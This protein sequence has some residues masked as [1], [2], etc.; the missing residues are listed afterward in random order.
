M[1]AK[2]LDE[3]VKHETPRTGGEEAGEAAGGI[4]GV[5]LGAAIGSPAGPIGTIIGGIAGAV[6][7]WWAGRAVVDATTRFTHE[8]DHYYRERYAGSPRRLD[9]RSY[10]QVRA[11][12]QLGH[13]AA[14]NP[15]YRGCSFDDIEGDLRSGWESQP[16]TPALG[17]DQVK[18]YV[19]EGYTRSAESGVAEASAPGDVAADEAT[20]LDSRETPARADDVFRRVDPNR[21]SLSPEGPD[22]AAGG[23]QY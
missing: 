9:D 19:E 2:P 14:L 16:Q 20:V 22:A 18:G 11:A 5:A 23:K 4:S 15:D 21:T 6:G 12:Y 17:W 3:H 10:D 7:G 13:I 8:D 1:D